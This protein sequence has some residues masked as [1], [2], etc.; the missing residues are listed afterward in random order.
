[1]LRR[2]RRGRGAHLGVSVVLRGEAFAGRRRLGIAVSK[3]SGHAPARA[4]LRRLLREAFRGLRMGW[5]ALDLVVS[6]GT[7]WP[8]ARL[9]DVAAELDGLVCTALSRR[10]KR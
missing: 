9:A 4:R 8:D 6:C 3:R 10:A 1:V 2:G 5:P 7:P